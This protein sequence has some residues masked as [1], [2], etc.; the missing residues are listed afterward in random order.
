[1]SGGQR[2]GDAPSIVGGILYDGDSI[3][4]RMAKDV[5]GGINDRGGI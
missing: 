2:R 1:M 4:R 3:L 5:F